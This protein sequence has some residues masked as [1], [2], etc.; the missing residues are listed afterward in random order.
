[1]KGD[2]ALNTGEGRQESEIY[3]NNGAYTAAVEQL[4]KKIEE[5]IGQY[6]V[7]LGGSFQAGEMIQG[8][9]DLQDVAKNAMMF[10][11]IW[12]ARIQE[13]AELQPAIRAI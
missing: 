12:T 2:L 1:M 8:G 4:A 13:V 10:S 7:G 6:V 5:A 3:L 11:G 9:Y